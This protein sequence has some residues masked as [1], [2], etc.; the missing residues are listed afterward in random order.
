[1]KKMKWIL[2]F[3]GITAEEVQDLGQML[4]MIEDFLNW[5]R[6]V[7]R[8]KGGRIYWFRYTLMSY[9]QNV[10]FT[11]LTRILSSIHFYERFAVNVFH[12]VHRWVS[13]VG[14]KSSSRNYMFLLNPNLYYHSH[15]LR[16]FWVL[17]L[18]VALLKHL[19]DD[20]VGPMWVFFDSL[21][22]R[23][24]SPFNKKGIGVEVKSSVMQLGWHYI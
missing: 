4:R 16:A 10:N 21:D 9:E 23:M 5:L 14:M 2:S 7:L 11:L 13:D 6:A 18:P 24:A 12:N 17:K 3:H 19:K 20:Q 1:M 22:D 15:Q 8:V